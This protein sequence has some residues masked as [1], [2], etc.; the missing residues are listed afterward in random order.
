[1]YLGYTLNTHSGPQF[2]SVYVH[3]KKEYFNTFLRNILQL[4]WCLQTLSRH[5]LIFF[6]L[7]QSNSSASI[8]YRCWSSVCLGADIHHQKNNFVD[9]FR[10]NLMDNCSRCVA[11]SCRK[12]SHNICGRAAIKCIQLDW[13]TA[14]K[15]SQ[16]AF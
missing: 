4:V 1:M 7:M 15:W 5:K 16:R 8:F 13:I 2:I 14:L 12:H 10:C 11:T 3:F 9:I 6:I